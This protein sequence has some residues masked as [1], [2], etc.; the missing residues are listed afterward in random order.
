M[1]AK[2]ISYM[3]VLTFAGALQIFVEPTLLA[4]LAQVGGETWSLNQLGLFFAFTN[5]DFASS[6]MLSLL[7]LIVSLVVAVVLI[8]RTDIF[9][10]E[11]AE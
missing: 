7:L 2:Y 10:T 1:I 3:L 4:Q 8:W 5:G 6:A 11:V 9:S